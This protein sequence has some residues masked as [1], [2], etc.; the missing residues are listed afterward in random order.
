M[1]LS[2]AK[3]VSGLTGLALLVLSAMVQKPV[4]AQ[5]GGVAPGGLTSAHLQA[6]ARAAE[7][8]LDYVPGELLVKFREGSA[9]ARQASVLALARGGAATVSSLWIRDIMHVR[10]DREDDTTQLAQL[11]MMQPEVE[12]AQPNY[13]RRMHSVPNDTG[14]QAQWNMA[15][16]D[17]PR[18]WDITDGGSSSVTVAVIDSGVT[19]QSFSRAFSLWTG[20]GFS[21]FSIPFLANPDIGSSRIAAS[22]DYSGVGA[23]FPGLPVWD[24]EGH[25]SHVAGTILQET[26]NA[27]GL[28]GMAY[29]TKLMTLKACYSH[30]DVRLYDGAV[31]FPGFYP[32]DGGCPD[33]AIVRSI[34]YAADNG[35]K[36]A[37]LSIGGSQPNPAAQSALRYAVGKGVFIAISAG[38][39]YLEGNPT[40]YPA[41][42]APNIEGV[43]A[44]G[45]IGPTGKRAYYSNT[46]TYV[47]IAA[48]GGDQTNGDQDGIYQASI[49]P[50]DHSPNLL[51]PRFDRYVG[52]SLQGTS[53]ASPHV[54]GLAAL[55]ASRGVTNPAAIEAA[56]KKFAVDL[57]TAGRD[58]EF[59]YGL[60][61]PPTTLRG[62]GFIR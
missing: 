52:L 54:A 51:V 21:A 59:G 15:L 16:L 62:L 18:A 9:P 23:A 55:L 48:P 3:A 37:N 12:W 40:S 1:L 47:E 27:L 56:I 53:M 14:Y 22:V 11:M 61:D 46:G 58:S 10:A 41:A 13:I 26:N 2:A 60:I 49:L 34:T 7:Q 5:G 39:E 31:G 24:T 17:M 33:D 30:W 36:V 44:V 50:S 4:T 19:T 38:N 35:A 29:Q 6:R 32:F 25:G 28:A 43:M 8:G 20:S 42:F 57:G 45:A